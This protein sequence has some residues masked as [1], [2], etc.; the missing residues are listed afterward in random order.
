MEENQPRMDKSQNAEIGER[1]VGGEGKKS[2]ELTNEEKGK[3]AEKLFEQYLDKEKFLY[4]NINQNQESQA[5]EFKDKGI[6][7]PDYEINGAY[8]VD[9]KYRKGRFII[10]EYNINGL[11]NFQEEWGK[12]VWLAF[13]RNLDV[14]QF[15]YTPISHIYT[16]Y[17]DIQEIYEKKNYKNFN[18]K[19]I[20]IPDIMLFDQIYSEKI[21]YK[22]P[23]LKF[24]EEI[25]DYI[26]IEEGYIAYKGYQKKAIVEALKNRT[27]SCLPEPNGYA[28]TQP[29]FNPVS[30]VHYHNDNLLFLKNLQ[31]ENGF[32]TAKYVTKEDISEAKKTYPK[33]LIREGQHSVNFYF[34]NK[35]DQTGK[36]ET[37]KV[38]LFNV[39]QT[40]RPDKMIEWAE[41]KHREWLELQHGTGYE[42]PEHEPGPEIVCSSTDPVE[43]LGQYFSAV[44]MGRQFKVSKEYAEEF[45]H[46]M[47]SRLDKREG[48]SLT[49]LFKLR[50]ICKEAG[51]YCKEFI[52][53]IRKNEKNIKAEQSKQ[54]LD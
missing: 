13:T 9:V 12:N 52:K 53:E 30:D 33:L 6:K 28:D 3:E 44:S 48:N 51:Q 34:K 39:A 49:N 19:R 45:A 38:R 32:P 24:L 10:D 1:S 22:R 42:P 15:Y 7:R 11:L 23:D 14:P 21:P 50:K 26:A 4:I 20:Y 35:N 25:V 17:K 46:K 27:L 29:A 18:K 47:I 41:Q 37:K 2:E 5:K 43:Y 54:K 36:W 40:T 16:Y 31:K 8:C